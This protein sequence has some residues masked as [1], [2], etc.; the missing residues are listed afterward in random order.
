MYAQH[1]LPFNISIQMSNKIVQ[2][3]V[4]NNYLIKVYKYYTILH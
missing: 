3:T 1:S 2:Q 4:I